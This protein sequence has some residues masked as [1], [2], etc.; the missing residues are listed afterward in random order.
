MM[1]LNNKISGLIF[2]ILLAASAPVFSGGKDTEND[3]FCRAMEYS[4][5]GDLK[6][7]EREFNKA[8][9]PNQKE[10]RFNLGIC[11]YQSKD[12]DRALREFKRVQKLDNKYS[13]AYY[14][15]GLASEIK[16]IEKKIG[17]SMIL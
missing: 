1:K 8:S 13:L 16:F 10:A 4:K 15:E 17:Q 11:Y 5:H 14:Y 12:Y 6:N 9:R 7:A 2:I 3:V